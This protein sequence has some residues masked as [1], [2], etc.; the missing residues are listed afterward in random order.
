MKN[1][2][3]ANTSI[4]VTYQRTHMITRNAIYVGHPNL[5]RFQYRQLMNI[6]LFNTL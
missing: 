5:K 2:N 4:S 6:Y 1:T 3:S